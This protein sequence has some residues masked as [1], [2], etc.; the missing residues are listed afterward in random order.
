MRPYVRELAGLVP[1]YTS[2]HPNAGLPNEFGG[3]DLGPDEL[4]DSLAEFAEAGWV[5]IVG[6]CCGTTP[7]HIAC[8]A[9][10]VQGITPRRIP[11]LPPRT[12][13]SGQEALVF[14][15]DSNFIMVG[16]RTNVTGSRRFARLIRE[17]E[18]D[19][20]IE[21]ARQQVIAGASIIDINMD[22]ALLDGEA[23]MTRFLN[24]IAAEPDIARVPVMID[25]SKW[26]VLEAGLKCLQGKAIVNSISLKDGETEFLRR[27]RLIRRYGAAVIVMA[28]DEHGQATGLDDRLRI[29]RRAYRLLTEQAGYPPQDIVFDPNVLTVGT[30]IAEHCNY[31]VDFIE[32]T[33]RLKQDYPETK[34]SGGI[35]NVSFAFRGNNVVREAMH[36]AFL[37]HAIRA[38]LDMGIVNAG[39]LAIYEE[40]PPDLLE[41]VEDVLL[42]R[43][44]DATE[45]LVAF[46]ESVKGGKKKQQV[47]DL[48]WRDQDVAERLMY[49]LVK[50][51]DKFI[52]EDA[53]A[54]RRQ[55]AT[56][57]E[58]IEGPLM[59]GMKRVG[60]LFGAGKMFLPQVVKTARVMKKAVA[61]LMPYLE[62]EKKEA[63]QMAGREIA[64]HNSAR[65]KVLMATVK[66][67]VHDIG[68]NI[69]GIVLGCNN[70]DVIDLGVMVPC[71]KILEEAER[72]KVDLIGLS[73]LI[74]PSL[75]E[76]VQVATSM[77]QRGMSI[78]LLIGGATTSEKH[79]AVKIAPCYTGPVVYVRD[80]SRSSG[81]VERLLSRESK[82]TF[83]AEN[84]ARQERLRAAF[85]QHQRTYVTLD[86][87]RRNRFRCDWQAVP[88]ER[89]AFLG[90][91]VLDSVDLGM[92]VDYIDWSPF[93]SAWELTGKFPKIL[94][95]P[96]KGP[97]ARELY[98]H[99]QQLL[100]KIVARNLL[101]ARAVYGFWPAAS[102]GDDIIVYADEERRAEI[103]RF[104][105]LRQQ[106]QRRGQTEF[107][108]L[109]D[110]IA[111]V[112]SKRPDYLGAFA[113]TAGI[114]VSE[115][116]AEYERQHDDYHAIMVR[117]LADRL[118][119]A[120]AEWL[121]REARCDWGYGRQ[122]ELSNEDLIAER[123]RGIRPAPGYPAQPDHTEKKTLFAL[124]DVERHTGIRLTENLAMQPAASV[125]GLYFAHPEA[126][127]FAVG[128]IQPD[129]LADYA[130]RKGM[131]IDEAQRWLRSNLQ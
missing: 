47:E 101:T 130:A 62:A 87:A 42:N 97:A 93:F 46:A 23:A 64:Q 98:E 79:T 65:G 129:Q 60:D 121:H 20:A 91:R 104:Y 61:Y 10:R 37:Y 85:T 95:D 32:A 122:E 55:Y 39:Q 50:G 115:L 81:T 30:G 119:E 59:D 69:V 45:R 72:Q 19:T 13:L 31:A 128:P 25:S 123:Y 38:G 90:P 110:Y 102:Q 1:I 57:L 88:I 127:Y 11:D 124:L 5:N 18:Y 112:E 76:M 75:D 109:A 6:G 15:P 78:P 71:E 29:L 40:V 8:V 73:G 27:A 125:C 107:R 66:G 34:V 67:D 83:V 22:D 92:L 52:E 41:R 56:C 7:Q 117:A 74:T 94:E 131:S 82:A 108:A 63:D 33:R 12:Q 116:V 51:I 106:W 70:Y 16:E 14:R 111:P 80:A 77:Q 58:I 48:G 17:G 21:V 9:E 118:A 103:A 54:A 120:L 96:K 26:S 2:C 126:R 44:P 99:V 35:S 84:Q 105:T 113:V 114:G 4:A 89:P 49:A 36:A 86:E 24:L 43:R 3:F 28:F 53:E 100:R 68:K